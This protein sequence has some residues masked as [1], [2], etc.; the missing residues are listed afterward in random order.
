MNAFFVPGASHTRSLSLHQLTALDAP[1]ARLIAI[2]GELG[3]SHV[4]LFTFVPEAARHVYPLVSAADVPALADALQ[5][6]SVRLCNLEVFPLDS[7]APAARFDAAL[8]TGAK[9]GAS[10]A[11]A[12][13]HNIPMTDLNATDLKTATA[14]F[15]S[16]CDQA[17]GHGLKAGLEFNGFSAVKNAETAEAIVR[18]AARA[19]GEVVL[20]LLHLV[21]S[22]GSAKQVAQ[23]ADLI[24]Y[25][26]ICDGP[27]HIAEDA[28]WREAVSERM[29]PGEGAFPLRNLL[30]PLRP[31]TLVE[32]EVPQTAARKAG[33]SALERARRAVEASRRLLE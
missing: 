29:L 11:T 26:Q 24:C 3:F 4:S 12:H 14:R 2:A 31:D 27:L 23:L 18:G 13:I 21:R 17:A 32:V 33:V 1:P 5:Q 20:D 7:D 6:A 16:F 22:G 15:A 19:N 25:A 9:L 28:R 8:A 10:R 30:E